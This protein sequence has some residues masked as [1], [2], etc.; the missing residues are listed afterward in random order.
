[1][2]I[3]KTRTNIGSFEKRIFSQKLLSCH[4]VGQHRQYMLNRN[5]RPLTD[6]ELRLPDGL[7]LRG[8]A[9]FGVQRDIAAA[10]YPRR[11]RNSESTRCSNTF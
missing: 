1:M 9:R 7:G 11:E 8:C 5:S 4:T 2:R 10:G 6:R 3:S